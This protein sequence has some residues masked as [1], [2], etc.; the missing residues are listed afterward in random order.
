MSVQ[1]K[2][3]S[4]LI[5]IARH[6]SS[7]GRQVAGALVEHAVEA[8][9]RVVANRHKCAALLARMR[10]LQP[11]VDQ[12]AGLLDGGKLGGDGKADGAAAVLVSI[13]GNFIQA[14]QLIND[15]CAPEPSLL[16]A[17]CMR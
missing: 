15:W 4:A 3:R 12:I 6:A 16:C 10:L 17:S 1:T 7:A 14:A 5:L 9:M 13:Q 8:Y 2:C 11:A